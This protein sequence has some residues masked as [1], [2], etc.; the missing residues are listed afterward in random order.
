MKSPTHPFQVSYA[1]ARGSQKAVLRLGQNFRLDFDAI[2]SLLHGRTVAP[3]NGSLANWHGG[4]RCRSARS[5][6]ASGITGVATREI[7]VKIEVIRPDFWARVEVLEALQE[8]IEFITGDTWEFEFNKDPTRYEW[9]VAASRRQ[10][11]RS[12]R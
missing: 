8:A 6:Q 5:T 2:A 4:L 7:R 3:S 1:E 12:V 11:P 9:T 10:H